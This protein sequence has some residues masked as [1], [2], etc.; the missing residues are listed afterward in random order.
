MK[1]FYFTATGNSM[2]VAKRLGGD[3]ISIPQALREEN[4][5]VFDDV[6]GFVF[7]TY[8][9]T[10]PSIVEE[11]I[12][13]LKINSKYV[14]TIMTCG[15]DNGNAINYFA[16]LLSKNSIKVNYSN[17][18]YMVGNHIPLVNVED[19][20]KTNRNVE[21]QIDII[22][23]E[24]AI[25]KELATKKI[26]HCEIKRYVIK[27]A[28]KVLPLDKPINFSTNNNC[29]KCSICAKVCPR[30]NVILN[31]GE[32][33]WGQQCEYCLACVHNC[34]KVA[35]EV[36]KDKSPNVRYRNENIGL[37]EIINSNNQ[38]IK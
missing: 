37:D 32:V 18:V 5:E 11:F 29:I 10:I 21:E 38:I 35:I 28:H 31:N 13:K 25:K 6:L 34:P 14:F 20:I 23:K 9:A 33:S 8:G 7:P 1:I 36:K 2:Y 22:K 30:K 4:F 24:I 15:D 3:V 26:I 27:L 17:V 12:S 19:E 16:N